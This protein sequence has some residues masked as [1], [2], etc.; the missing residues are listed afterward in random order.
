MN[1]SYRWVIVAA[2]GA[3]EDLTLRPG[4]NAIYGCAAGAIG[5]VQ[6]RVKYTPAGI[7]VPPAVGA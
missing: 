6:G 5:G 2:G 3:L 7:D 1:H 4:P